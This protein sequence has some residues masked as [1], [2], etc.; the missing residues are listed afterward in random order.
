VDQGAGPLAELLFGMILRRITYP[1][2]D[3]TTLRQGSESFALFARRQAFICGGLPIFSAQNFPASD[4]QAI[5]SS[6]LGPDCAEANVLP[7]NS[8]T[9]ETRAGA[10]CEDFRADFFMDHLI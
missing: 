4:R 6:R 1:P 8:K 10:A 9:S 5:C 2:R 7:A 3:S